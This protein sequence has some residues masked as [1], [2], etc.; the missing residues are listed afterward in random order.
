MRT[1]HYHYYR[2]FENCALSD[3]HSGMCDVRCVRLMKMKVAPISYHVRCILMSESLIMFD[4]FISKARL[5]RGMPMIKPK[6]W[7][8]HVLFCVVFTEFMISTTKL[9]LSLSHYFIT[10]C[11]ENS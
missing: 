10:S 7:C 9:S 4:V 8:I 3:E 5:V 1:Y 2:Y 6:L 11:T